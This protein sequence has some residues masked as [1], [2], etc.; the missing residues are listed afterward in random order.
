MLVGYLGGK[1]VSS[2]T[3]A[4]INP[5]IPYPNSQRTWIETSE[6]LLW[7]CIRKKYA[8]NFL[9]LYFGMKEDNIFLDWNF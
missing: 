6:A 3:T 9:A 1:D 7:L 5:K 2:H 8:N 4:L